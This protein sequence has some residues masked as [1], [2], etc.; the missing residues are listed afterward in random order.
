VI[1]ERRPTTFVALLA[2]ALFAGCSDSKH[3]ARPTPAPSTTEAAAGG[4]PGESDRATLTGNATLDGQPFDARYMGAVVL[5][6][7]G[8]VTACQLTL[9]PVTDGRYDIT[10]VAESEG[11]G[12]GAPAAR[13]VPWVFA[14]NRIIYSTN[15]APWPGNGKRATANFTFNSNTPDGAQP[16]VTQFS[17]NVH[18]ATGDTLSGGTKVE[19]YVGDTL[20]GVASTRYTGAFDGYILSVV[21]PSSVAACTKG[22]SL[23]LLVDGK[24]VRQSATNDLET[25]ESF[26]LT[27]V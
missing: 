24:P 10:V 11:A 20:C 2:V 17:G 23:R 1:P 14:K 12:C 7:D 9:P 13:V 6:A 19:A 18:N 22:A 15:A 16:P 21:G 26:D 8:L 25:H 27:T 4:V 3:A 5:R